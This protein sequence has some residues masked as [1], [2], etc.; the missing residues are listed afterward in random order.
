MTHS[1][2]CSSSF[3]YLAK[4]ARVRNLLSLHLLALPDFFL[5]YANH[6]L[7]KLFFW[8]LPF[9]ILLWSFIWATRRRAAARERR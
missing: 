1:D 8:A 5:V 2:K 7:E 3:D 4:F 9:F 6:A